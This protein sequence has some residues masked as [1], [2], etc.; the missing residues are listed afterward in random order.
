MQHAEIKHMAEVLLIA[1]PES[2]RNLID[3]VAIEESKAD[4][5]DG[6]ELIVQGRDV[7]A[8]SMTSRRFLSMAIS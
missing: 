8:V 5:L 3:L 2:E 4:I 7:N 1:S 6:L